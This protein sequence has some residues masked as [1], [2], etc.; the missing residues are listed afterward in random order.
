MQELTSERG[1]TITRTIRAS[2]KRVYQAFLD[3]GAVGRWFGPEGFR[4][5][6]RSM[7][8][9]V[10]GL[11][12]FTMA[13]PDGTVFPNWVRYLELAPP[14]RIVWDHG[15]TLGEPAWFRMTLRFDEVPDG[16]HVTLEQEHPSRADRDRAVK[17]HG[18]IEGGHQTLA[19]LAAYLE[20]A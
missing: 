2:R 6:T 7:D 15:E 5:E 11:W 10:G 1:I 4:T 18:A 20:G 3:S 9:R 12:Q 14:E 16:T 8:A 13:G 17:D 19:R